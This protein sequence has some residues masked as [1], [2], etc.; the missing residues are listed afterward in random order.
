MYRGESTPAAQSAPNTGAFEYC[1]AHGLD[2]SEFNP[3]NSAVD[4]LTSA[5]QQLLRVKQ[6]ERQQREH[7][8]QREQDLQKAVMEQVAS[9]LIK[10]LSHHMGASNVLGNQNCDA[11]APLPTGL[12]APLSSLLGAMHH[13][14]ERGARRELNNNERK[15]TQP[16]IPSSIRVRMGSMAKS[17]YSSSFDSVETMMPAN[18]GKRKKVGRNE[19]ALRAGFTKA[20][21]F[22]SNSPKKV[23]AV[24]ASLKRAKY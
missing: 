20:K 1:F 14:D 5:A 23:A 13:S 3:A 17:R 16:T 6:L 21:K 2:L 12:D 11:Q 4:Q 18:F 10:E 19:A 15:I 22:E 9:R 8:A 24:K 7:E